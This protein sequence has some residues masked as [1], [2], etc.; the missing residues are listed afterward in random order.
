MKRVAGL[1]K[2]ESP[3]IS[4]SQVGATLFVFIL[5]FG[6]TFLRGSKIQNP[7]ARVRGE[8]R[9]YSIFVCL[10]LGRVN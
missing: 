3:T 7:E 9:R 6:F 5:F 1:L 4:S 8:I 10:V 2:Q